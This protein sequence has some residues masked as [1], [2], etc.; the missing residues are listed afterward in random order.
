MTK[1]FNSNIDLPVLMTRLAPVLLYVL[2][3]FIFKSFITTLPL[4]VPCCFTLAQLA[5]TK[6]TLTSEGY[7][8]VKSGFSNLKVNIN[9][10]TGI[11][12]KSSLTF[13]DWFHTYA[14]SKNGLLIKYGNNRELI[15]SPKHGEDF[16]AKLNNSNLN[17]VQE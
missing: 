16:L 3:I 4:V 11:L 10:I 2:S 12:P 5:R 9:D 8:V 6:Y 13:I 15:I 14:N 7:L 1:S 17:G